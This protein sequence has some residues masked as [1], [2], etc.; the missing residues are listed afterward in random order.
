M[1]PE[2]EPDGAS[3]AVSPAERVFVEGTVFLGSPPQE[4]D[5]LAVEKAAGDDVPLAV[6]FLNLPVIERMAHG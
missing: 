4:I 2:R 3:L 6:V 5:L 1:V